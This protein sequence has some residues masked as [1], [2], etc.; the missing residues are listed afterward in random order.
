M[1]AATCETPG[2]PLRHARGAWRTSRPSPSAPLRL[3][4]HRRHGRLDDLA[5]GNG[6]GRLGLLAR[7]DAREP[8]EL[9]DQL[10]DAPHLVEARAQRLLVLARRPR[11][12]ER[13]LQLC[14]ET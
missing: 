13:Y 5:H 2:P 1:T 12:A 3:R 10:L 8:E 9:L 7:V 4:P 6:L 14:P 11:S